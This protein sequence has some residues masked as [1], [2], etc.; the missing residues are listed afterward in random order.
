MKAVGTIPTKVDQGAALVRLKGA[1][2]SVELL[3]AKRA[4]KHFLIYFISNDGQA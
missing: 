2:R 4:G 1:V 3:D